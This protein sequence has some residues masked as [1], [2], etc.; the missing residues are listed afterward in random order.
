MSPGDFDYPRGL[1]RRP[2]V[3]KP[4]CF[5]AVGQDMKIALSIICILIISVSVR[6]IIGYGR[7]VETDRP[8][9]EEIRKNLNIMGVIIVILAIMLL[10]L[11]NL[12]GF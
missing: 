7:M 3:R 6:G 4:G 8:P 12:N 9:P 10:V 11:V 1:G 2:D 5:A